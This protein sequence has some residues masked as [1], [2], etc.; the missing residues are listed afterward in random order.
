MLTPEQLKERRKG[1]GAS[2]AR[3]IVDGAWHQLWLEKTGKV[4][5]EDLSGVWPVQLGSHTESL[6]LDWY[7]RVVGRK[8]DRRGEPVICV[9]YHILRCTLD[10]Y[11]ETAGAVVEAKHVNAYSKIDDVRAR[12]VPQCQHQMICTGAKNAVLSVIIGANE[13]VLE[14]IEYDEF[15]AAEYVEKCYQFWKHVE[16]N[17]PPS[18]GAPIAEPPPPTVM[19]V[20]DMSG[21]NAWGSAAADW[22]AHKDHAKKF[23][24]AVKDL[25][26]MI[27]PDVREAS[28]HGIVISRNKAGSLSIKE[29]RNG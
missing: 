16:D 13:P 9:E 25:K 1:I 15:F 10:G 2:D 11:D 27:E 17:T 20:V 14:L 3:K 8:V 4:E 29:K 6:N 22:L 23:D 21:S 28:G 26:A 7:E 19:R 5:A 12:Y 18:D 24:L